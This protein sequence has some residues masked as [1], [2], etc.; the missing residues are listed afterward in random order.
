MLFKCKNCGGN[1][2]YDP[3]MEKM[4]CPHC[5]GTDCEEKV[6]GSGIGECLNC[7]APLE[8]TD[9]TSAYKCPHCGSYLI[10][11]QRVEGEYLPHLILPFK[12]GKEQAAEALK[13]EFHKRVFTP[14]S[15]L[16]QASIDSMEGS[17]VPFFMYDFDVAASYQA[18][19]TKI[20][21]WRSGDTEYTETSYYNV[22]RDMDINFDRIPVDASKNMA[23]DIMDLMEPYDY[24]ALRN[25]EEKY[26][27][28]FL[29][30]KYSESSGELEPRAKEKADKAAHLLLHDSVAGYTTLT[31]VHENIAIHNKEMKY[32]L[33][34]V[35]VYTFS[36]RGE[37]YKFHVNGQTGKVIGVTPV[38]KDKVMGYSATVFAICTVIGILLRTILG[39]F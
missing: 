7:G 35:W 37:Q 12:I 13:K 24:K 2:V 8:I 10:F 36:Y 22:E 17:Y 20:R 23:D 19:G 29:A 14:S 18:K 39:V 34:P 31:Q 21:T 3:Q 25:F 30:E 1:A 9:D 6:V 5:E 38:A 15:F 26:M 4:Y 16:S 32:A 11:E 33:L 27:S 28:G